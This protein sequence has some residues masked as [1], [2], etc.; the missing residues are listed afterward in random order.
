MVQ[1]DVTAEEVAAG[2][3]TPEHLE[4]AVAAVLDDGFVVLADV[5]SAASLD[6]LHERMLAD[7]ALLTARD[8]A[9]FNWNVGNLQQDPPPF[10]PYL[11]KDVLVNELIIQVTSGV[12][13]G[14]VKNTMYGGNTALP[15][16]SRQPVHAD[17]GHLWPRLDVAHPPVQLVVN[18]ATVDVSPQNASTEIWPGTHKDLTVTAGKDIK[19]PAEIL[20]ARRAVCPPI[21]PSYRRGAAVIRDIRMWHAGM[22]NRTPNP[23]PMIAMIHVP[24]WFDVG[25]PLVF[26]RDAEPWFQHPVL[27]QAARFV[28][29]PIDHIAAPHG[30]EYEKPEK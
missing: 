14:G 22:P 11:F 26:P 24:W 9:P 20:E 2:T 1:V 21:Q 4:A 28:D 30:Y 5:V 10:H 12:L 8:D 7:I 29:G 6:A 23:R 18:V 27:R 15:S 19:I 16:E 17:S 13:G 25:T 3:L